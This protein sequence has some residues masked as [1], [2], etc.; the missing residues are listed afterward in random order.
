MRDRASDLTRR[1]T[2]KLAGA[3]GAFLALR[4][5]AR[6]QGKSGLHGLSIFG[7]LKYGP[8]FKNFDY[9]NPAAPK[10]GRMNFRYPTGTT[11]KI[12][13]PSTRSIPLC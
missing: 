11:I 3:T 1:T 2:L 9:V 10:G 4:P 8:D 13:R 12:R 5:F 7:D 6:A